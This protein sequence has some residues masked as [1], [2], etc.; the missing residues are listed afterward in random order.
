MVNCFFKPIL[1]FNFRLYLFVFISEKFI[2]MAERFFD[3]NKSASV[4]MCVSQGK[5]NADSEQ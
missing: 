5:Q 1:F 4:E 3:K 2:L